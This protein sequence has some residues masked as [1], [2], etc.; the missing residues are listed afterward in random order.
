MNVECLPKSNAE[1]EAKLRRGRKGILKEGLDARYDIFGSEKKWALLNDPAYVRPERLKR[2]FRE[3]ELAQS[4][5]KKETA[6]GDEDSVDSAEL[7]GAD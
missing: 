5:G 7:S 1:A 6:D 2:L 3:L 4:A